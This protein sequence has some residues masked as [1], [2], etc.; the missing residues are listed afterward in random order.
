MTGLALKALLAGVGFSGSALDTAYA[1]AMAES[2]GRPTAYNPSG[3]TG[4]FQIMPATAQYY[5]YTPSRLTDPIYNAQAAYAISRHGQDWSQWQ[6]YTS[7]AYFRYMPGGGNG[8]DTNYS[9]GASGMGA[10]ATSPGHD[11]GTVWAN[12]VKR[13]GRLIVAL[14]VV[15]A[16]AHV[17]AT[18]PIA[19]AIV[20][21][22]LLSQS[23][24]MGP[25][26][27]TAVIKIFGG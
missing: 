8:R 19:W 23:G 11:W 5:G 4:L 7:G 12:G 13:Y 25:A 9:G 3:A 22:A 17:Q 14:G 21:I 2:G 10:M 27:Q 1:V 18:R 24:V 26:M 20:L 15:G 6:T 16:L